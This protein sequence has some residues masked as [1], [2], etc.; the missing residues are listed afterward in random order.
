M[1][2]IESDADRERLID[3]AVEVLVAEEL[4]DVDSSLSTMRHRRDVIGE[5]LTRLVAEEIACVLNRARAIL[6]KAT[7]YA[8]GAPYEYQE[9]DFSH[10]APWAVAGVSA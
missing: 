4:D 8:S 5:V 10:G 7:H 3:Q 9:T 6:I 2:T 1:T